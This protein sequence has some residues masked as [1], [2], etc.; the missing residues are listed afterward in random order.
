[1]LKQCLRRKPNV[2]IEWTDG[3]FSPPMSVA[4]AAEILK[5]WCGVEKPIYYFENLIV[6]AAMSIEAESYPDGTEDEKISI[7][8]KWIEIIYHEPN[9]HGRFGF[10]RITYLN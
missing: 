1:M 6:N 3:R 9:R 2:Q 7:Q 4:E 8:D 5:E 10:G